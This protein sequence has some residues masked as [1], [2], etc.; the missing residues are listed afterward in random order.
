[1]T[2]AFL[3]TLLSSKVTSSMFSRNFTGTLGAFASLEGLLHQKWLDVHHMDQASGY[4]MIYTWQ[5]DCDM[6]SFRMHVKSN[7][8]FS[9][10][11]CVWGQCW[12]TL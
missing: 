2:H 8:D 7:P 5:T 10:P 6:E 1:V 12:H 3:G 11:P 9:D 4:R